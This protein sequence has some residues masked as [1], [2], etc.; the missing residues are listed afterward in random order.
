MKPP[1][2]SYL[3]RT[4][5]LSVL[6]A[7]MLVADSPRA[8]AQAN[9]PS[10]SE[11]STSFN[12]LVDD[13]TK[14]VFA[15]YP[16]LFATYLASRA[17]G[18]VSQ[19]GATLRQNPNPDR[20]T[21]STAETAGTTTLTEKTGFSELLNLAIE[22]GAIVKKTSGSSYTLQTTPYLLYS[23]FGTNDTAATWDQYAL[24]RKI[25][26]SATFDQGT[27]NQQPS[28]N[29]FERAEVKYIWGGRSARDKGFRDH[30]WQLLPAKL[31]QPTLMTNKTL[32]LFW[33]G[34]PPLLRDALRKAQKD[35]VDWRKDWLKDNP[36]P[37]DQKPTDQASID[38][39]ARFRQALLQQLQTRLDSIFEQLNDQDR[40]R[41]ADLAAAI[42][43]QQG[44]FAAA[45]DL[46][47]AEAKQYL[48]APHTEVSFAYSF[49]RDATISDFSDFKL[50]AAY[51]TGLNL[52]ANLNGEIMLNNNRTD[53]SGKRLDTIRAYSL[54]GDLTFGKFANDM[55][56]FTAAAKWTRPQGGARDER[57]A[58]AKL[59]LYLIRSMTI[60]IS[61]TYSDKPEDSTRSRVR[62]N[63]GLSMDADALMGAARNQS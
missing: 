12:K 31:D 25:S 13:A 61:L 6:V 18:V 22:T 7:S 55:F 47:A 1:T 26:L 50:I 28:S 35:L 57:F 4:A 38:R 32:S 62:F 23:K 44:A 46:V 11:S 30:L 59:N 37:T 20:Q 60:P 56:D 29:N 53:P 48:E 63:V 54:E 5:V 43:I 3:I 19:V 45:S 2:T 16:D 39:Q 24:F 14:E 33:N 9:E 10:A 15:D 41:L 27:G 17:R 21:G 34:L 36:V 40:T 8:S 51:K 49:Q 52:S 58:Q 42:E